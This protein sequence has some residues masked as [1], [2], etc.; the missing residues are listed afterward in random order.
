MKPVDPVEAML[1]VI[2][3]RPILA[4]DVPKL[5][6][7]KARE[8]VDVPKRIYQLAKQVVRDET[9]DVPLGTI[10]YKTMLDQLFPTDRQAPDEAHIVDMVSKFPPVLHA[11]TSD[12]LV[13]ASKVIGYLRDLFPRQ[14]KQSLTGETN[15][16]PS[17][18]AV[19]R[20]VT[21]LDVIDNPF[22]VFALISTGS[23][24]NSQRQAVRTVYPTISTAIDDAFDEA[25]NYE[26]VQKKSWQFPPHVQIG[27]SAWQGL[28]RLPNG[29]QTR[30]QKNFAEA[31][32]KSNSQPPKPTEGTSQS[33]AA[34]E[35]LTNTQRALFP[36]MSK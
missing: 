10:N 3:V 16:A 14:T 7:E 28:P 26:L 13:E 22:H 23:L 30:L 20:F 4:K 8:I 33:I 27:L 5:T 11:V 19:R 17:A 31:N 25:K 9:F 18:L 35:S 2:G 24:L 12:F 6:M 34:K 36:Q 1:A 21:T 15:I 29:M 32:V